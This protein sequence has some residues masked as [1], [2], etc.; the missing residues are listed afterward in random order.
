MMNAVFARLLEHIV[1]LNDTHD[2]L[3]AALTRPE[4]GRRIDWPGTITAAERMSES[5]AR[6]VSLGN[7]SLLPSLQPQ[8]SLGQATLVEISFLEALAS[9]AP[10]SPAHLAAPHPTDPRR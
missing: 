4:A 3:T 10:A 2:A 8:K 9:S 6:L 7:E 1:A 5:I